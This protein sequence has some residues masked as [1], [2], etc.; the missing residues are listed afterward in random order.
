MKRI[1][2]PLF[3]TV[4]ILALFFMMSLGPKKSMASEAIRANIRALDTT[5][6]Q[7]GG[8]KDPT[9]QTCYSLNDIECHDTSGC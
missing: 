2:M 3:F 5:G 4:P 8:P 9:T 1:K 6:S 7:C